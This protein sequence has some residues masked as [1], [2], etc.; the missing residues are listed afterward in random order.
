MFRKENELM[1][2]YMCWVGIVYYLMFDN[3]YY[4]GVILNSIYKFNEMVEYV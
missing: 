1:V 2:G 4:D 3:I